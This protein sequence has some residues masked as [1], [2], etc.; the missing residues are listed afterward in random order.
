MP[1]ELD[2]LDCRVQEIAAAADSAPFKPELGGDPVTAP[3]DC[4]LSR[5]PSRGFRVPKYNLIYW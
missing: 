4:M 2:P 5:M 3:A 1:T